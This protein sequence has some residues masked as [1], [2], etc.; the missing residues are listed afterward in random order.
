MI[1]L[2]LQY[3]FRKQH[4]GVF[5]LMRRGL[6]MLFAVI[7]A[8][9]LPAAALAEEAQPDTPSTS[10]RSVEDFL[11]FAEGC[12]SDMYSRG[13]LFVLSADLDLSGMAFSPIPYFAGVFDGTNHSISGLRLTADGSRQGLFRVVAGG[14]QV[15][16]LTVRGNVSPGGTAC[17]VGGIVGVNSGSLFDCSFEGTVS[18]IQDVGGIVG[19]NEA[20]S[21]LTRCISEADIT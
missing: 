21:V 12:S 5:R 20:G 18:G 4:P 9:G 19:R 7:M 3:S 14:A 10:I 8:A 15:K 16:N 13:K 6:A 17:S 11:A 2:L 1:K